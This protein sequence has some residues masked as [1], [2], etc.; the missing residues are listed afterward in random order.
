VLILSG[1]DNISN[2]QDRQWERQS[3]LLMDLL[4]DM[5]MDATA[6]QAQDLF[7]GLDVLQGFGTREGY[8]I[9]CGNFV[10]A[11]GKAVF[12]AYRVFTYGGKKVGVL[13]VT[14]PRLQHAVQG[15]PAGYKFVDPAPVLA[16]GVRALREQEGC[17]AVVLLYG[18]RKEQAVEV[19]KTLTGVDLIFFGNSTISQRVPTETE[20]GVPLYS[21]ANRGKDFGEIQLTLKDDGTVVLSPMQVHELDK[22]YAEQPAI[23][24]RVAALKAELEGEKQRAQ[25]IEQLARETSAEAVT[26]AYLGTE[27]CK[28]CHQAEY[29]SFMQTAHAQALTSLEHDF[30]DNNPECVSCH[31]TGWQQ[32]GGYGLDATNRNK[33]KG[34]QCEACHGYGTAHT[35]GQAAA[36]PPAAMCLKCHDAANSPQFDYQRYWEQ[37]K[38]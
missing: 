11:G 16:D 33:L 5:G 21:A 8:A 31:V 3:L 36:A 23:A 4:G 30:Q 34:V 1:G 29:E 17:A 15:L 37:I 24:A 25:L 10:D 26:E 7:L 9:L 2:Q 14:D 27:T 38:H 18:G 13:A 22:S 28:R 20:A 19:C 12:P 6:V 35:R 32:P